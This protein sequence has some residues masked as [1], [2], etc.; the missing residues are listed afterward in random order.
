[1]TKRKQKAPARLQDYATGKSL[2]QVDRNLKIAERDKTHKNRKW[3][4]ERERRNRALKKKLQKQQGP[5]AAS[6]TSIPTETAV[7]TAPGVTTAGAMVTLSPSSSLK[8]QKKSS[9]LPLVQPNQMLIDRQNLTVDEWQKEMAEN[10]NKLGIGNPELS[11]SRKTVSLLSPAL[12]TE[13]GGLCYVTNLLGVRKDGGGIATPREF[14]LP[15][16]NP[17]LQTA[18]LIPLP[19]NSAHQKTATTKKKKKNASIIDESTR[20]QELPENGQDHL[21]SEGPRPSAGENQQ[22]QLESDLSS[23]LHRQQAKVQANPNLMKVRPPQQPLESQMSRKRRRS[24]SSTSQ[25]IKKSRQATSSTATSTAQI[26]GTHEQQNKEI[27]DGF[28]LFYNPKQ[29]SHL[30]ALDIKKFKSKNNIISRHKPFV[31]KF[32][33]NPII[34]TGLYTHLFADTI[35]AYEL[36]YEINDNYAYILVVVDGLSKQLFTA[37]LYFN[38]QKEV[39]AALERIF[40]H[41]DLPGHTFFLSDRGKEFELST[42][43]LLQDW[44]MSPVYLRGRHKSAPAERAM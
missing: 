19:P 28:D 24:E 42:W 23:L 34:A 9:E 44:G 43:P 16:M 38:D 41:L 2:Y 36:D 18:P 21:P 25:R 39:T 10:L 32:K 7:S 35:A 31:S 14:L 5:A 8:V 40:S 27:P 29:P 13:Q 30:S 22:Q 26:S 37:P 15:T 4:A 1:M 17:S 12:I 6:T 3:I 11:E 20:I 33:R